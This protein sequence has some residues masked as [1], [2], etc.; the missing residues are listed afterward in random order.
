MAVKASDAACRE[1][2]KAEW[3]EGEQ[4]QKG[5]TETVRAQHC[6]E[7]RVCSWTRRV[8]TPLNL[9]CSP[10]ELPTRAQ[11]ITPQAKSSFLDTLGNSGGRE[12]EHR[13]LNPNHSCPSGGS[14]LE[15]PLCKVP[16]AS[17]H[18]SVTQTPHPPQGPISCTQGP[19]SSG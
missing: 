17:T 14:G 11:S 1:L 10:E 15:L 2:Q 7:S 9:H 16:P 4:H 3:E 19:I 8:K 5:S 12:P 18:P 6:T 13:S